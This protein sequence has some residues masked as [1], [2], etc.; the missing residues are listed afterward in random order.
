MAQKGI[1]SVARSGDEQPRTG[2]TGIDSSGDS[3]SESG[4]SKREGRT[5]KLGGFD[6]IDSFDTIDAG[7]DTG[8]GLGID[9]G[10]RIEPQPVKRR[11]RPAGSKNRTSSAQEAEKNLV[12]DIKSLLVTTHMMLAKFTESK[13]LELDPME[14]AQMEA[15]IKNVAQ[16]YPVGMSAKKFAWTQL[17][18]GLATIYGSRA[19][20]IARRMEVQKKM[21]PALVEIPNK[22]PQKE[23]PKPAQEILVPSQLYGTGAPLEEALSYGFGD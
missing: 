17:G 13:E 20:A 10:I 21:K 3:K 22:Q 2:S 11:G 12:L 15:W 8:S 4:T 14:A 19:I 18:I 23:A 16:Y 7:N 9:D 1:E 6:L 5:Q